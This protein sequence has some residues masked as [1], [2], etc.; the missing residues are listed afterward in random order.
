MSDPKRKRR[1]SGGIGA[2]VAAG[3]LSTLF[4]I[5]SERTFIDEGG[6]A[7]DA[8][9]RGGET[10]WG[11]TEAVAR[12]QGYQGAMASLPRDSAVVW[13]QRLYWETIWGD[14]LAVLD[15]DLAA[16]VFDAGYNQGRS[17]A[18]RHLQRC[19]NG[20]NQQGRQ[21]PDV[22]VDG[23]MGPG[24]LRAVRAVFAQRRDAGAL[25]E[26]CVSTLQGARY[27]AIWERDPTQERFAVGW[28]RRLIPGEE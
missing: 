20:Y 27:I 19:V 13:A 21:W 12:R 24:T 25:L 18:V 22:A 1:W 3:I 6:Y 15:I 9:D 10:M 26:T 4:L 14:S 28:M 11:V 23:V 5:G 8:L 17:A 2:L 16:R 7:N